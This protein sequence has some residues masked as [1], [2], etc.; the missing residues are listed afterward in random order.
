MF[1]KTPP[2]NTK[3]KNHICKAPM[4]TLKLH[5]TS[6]IINKDSYAMMVKPINSSMALSNE[7]A[8]NNNVLLILCRPM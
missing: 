5:Y 8:Y 1:L 3:I 4:K 7:P 2:I 6:S